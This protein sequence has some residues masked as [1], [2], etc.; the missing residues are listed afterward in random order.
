MSTER[1][2]VGRRTVSAGGIGTPEPFRLGERLPGFFPHSGNGGVEHKGNLK[3]VET[4]G[5]FDDDGLSG[6]TG[7]ARCVLRGCNFAVDIVTSFEKE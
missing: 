2:E 3:V 7:K 1:F 5:S 4:N 6:N